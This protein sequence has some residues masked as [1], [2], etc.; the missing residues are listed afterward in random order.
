MGRLPIQQ[1]LRR[2]LSPE[3]QCAILSFIIL[4]A[5]LTVYA[6]VKQHPF[7]HIDDYGYVVNN[8]HLQ[9]L[10][11]ET[12]KWSFTT[13][14]YANWD[15]LT[16]LSHALDVQLFGMDPG[17]HHETSMLLHALNA[18]LLF[19][20]LWKATGYVGR[21]FV[22]ATIFA[23]HPVN[24]EPVAWVAERKTVLAMVFFL[25]TLIAYRWYARQP[26]IGRYLLVALLFA[27][28]LMSKPQIITLPFV[29]LL[30]DYWPLGRMFA[31]AEPLPDGHLAGETAGHA[32]AERT[33]TWLL[34]EKVPLLALSA[35]SAYLT[36]KAQWANRTLG[37]LNSYPF[38]VRL[39]NSIV[40][41]VRYLSHATWPTNL[42]FFYPHAHNAPPVG[43]LAGSLLLLL[44]ITVL[45]LAVRSYRYLVVGW[46]WFLGTLVPMIEVV[47]V[48]NHAMA[49]RYGYVSFVGLF[50]A[51]CWGIADWTER[52]RVARILLPVGSIAILLLLASATT[53]Q[54]SYWTDDLTLWTHAAEA[55]PN[56]AMAENVIGETLQQKG[57]RDA[58]MAHF[59]TAA[60]MDPLFPFP[61]LHLGVYEEEQRHPQEAIKTLQKV[62]DLT[63]GAAAEHMPAIRTE[64]FVH[65]SF[66]YAQLGDRA[67]Q[68]KYLNLAAQQ[69]RTE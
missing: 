52:W 63:Q 5:T 49:D 62:I 6:P 4:A 17:R 60:A 44:L 59:R 30:W 28:G 13:F 64:A 29:L 25:L 41:Y 35:G 51:L 11:W 65:M 47:Q 3:M 40:T 20:L 12:V 67:N 45:A 1:Q 24:V 55:V 18:V 23:L 22:V 10:N 37:G 15:P 56:N 32:L 42:A 43:Q 38:T 69:N 68:E 33:F 19:W 34:L 16:W 9:H 2:V 21:S 57:E 31:P 27:M 36:M 46:L 50:I 53:R 54:L 61:Y 58:A 7:I 39:S 26:A 48:G 66:A 14:H 8:T